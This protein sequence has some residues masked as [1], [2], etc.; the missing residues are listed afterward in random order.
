MK[1]IATLLVLLFLTLTA[2]AQQL[3]WPKQLRDPFRQDPLNTRTVPRLFALHFTDPKTIYAILLDK[4]NKLLS[5]DGFVVVQEKKR[6]ILVEDTPEQLHK[7]QRLIAVLDKPQPQL[8]LKARIVSVD[9][10]YAE[11]LGLL[12]ES[13]KKG[14]VAAGL[15]TVGSYTMPIANLGN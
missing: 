3:I 6:R 9:E 13:A 14:A 5:Q 15:A 2:Q 1:F 11:D 12:F 8:L 4:K 10:T 7:I